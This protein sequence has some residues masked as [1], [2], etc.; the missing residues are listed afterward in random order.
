MSRLSV[1]LMGAGQMGSNHARVISESVVA[2]LSVVIDPNP[3][4][5][6]PAIDFAR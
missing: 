6:L 4:A 3:V 1:A 2:R 5:A